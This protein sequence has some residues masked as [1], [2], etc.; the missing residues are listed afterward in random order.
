M[1]QYNRPTFWLLNVSTTLSA[2]SLVSKISSAM[3]LGRS[4]IR[5]QFNTAPPTGVRALSMSA[6]V[7]PAAK[8]FTTTVYGPASPRI[9]IA[10]TGFEEPTMLN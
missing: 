5:R 3:T 9:E 2:P 4:A 6:V 10:G 8:F 1:E 7:V